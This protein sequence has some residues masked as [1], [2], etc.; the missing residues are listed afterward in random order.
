VRGG[1]IAGL[2]VLIASLAS[3]T[4]PVRLL[5][6][7]WTDARLAF[8]AAPAEADDIVLVAIDEAS[9]AAMRA[10][11]DAAPCA[12]R[13]PL[14]KSWLALV[15]ADLDRMG[16]SVIALDALL[17]EWASP[18]QQTVFQSTAQGLSAKLVLLAPG[19]P[20]TLQA[21]L[22]GQARW[23]APDLGLIADY[24]AVVRVHD[25]APNGAVS[26]PAAI[27]KAV[28]ATVPEEPFLIR[29]RAPRAGQS[30]FPVYPAA[31]IAAA[32]PEWIAGKI[33]LIGRMEVGGLAT[34]LGDDVH[35]T[36]MRLRA[37]YRAGMAGVEAH[38]HITAQILSGRRLV[39]LEGWAG[40]P[41]LIA[42]ALVG[43]ALSR[44]PGSWAT[45]LAI[46]LAL[47]AAY[48]IGAA[49]LAALGVLVAMASPPLA[50]LAG[51]AIGNRALTGDIERDR[52]FLRRA[53]GQYLPKPVIADL[54]RRPEGLRL[55]ADRRRISVLASDVAGFSR[56]TQDLSPEALSALMNAYFDG[57][58]EILWR[59]GA[60]IDKLVG[61]GVF[62]IFGAPAPTMDHAA[63]AIAAARALDAFAEAFRKDAPERFGVSFGETRIGVETGEALVGNFGGRLRF[64]YTAYGE[65][66]VRAARLQ[67][68]NKTL[69]GRLLIGPGAAAEPHGAQLAPLAPITLPGI[70]E[71]VIP[72]RVA[73]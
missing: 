15:L 10:R 53:L 52:R 55:G 34:P 73:D 44:R 60:M 29:W 35:Q 20:E 46:A 64:D 9:I 71:E 8:L 32:P 26:L 67:A 72:Y 37:P 65:V 12:C 70:A 50:F 49:G 40:L 11:P 45:G 69:G 22:A 5:E 33:V 47:I 25:P 56:L 63:R 6:G 7:A 42:A 19:A 21:G 48:W 59:H 54:V 66:V 18:G 28:G 43:V 62:A 30:G 23:A 57:A 14:D 13:T 61:D 1:F 31:L 3:L 38:A 36:P 39:A 58:I 16:A 2:A 4:T 24:D 17:D 68:A 51:F 41:L 27:A